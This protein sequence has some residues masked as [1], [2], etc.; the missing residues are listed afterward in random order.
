M[1]PS[2]RGSISGLKK[3]SDS[4][5]GLNNAK[6]SLPFVLETDASGFGLGAVLMQS[7]HPIAFFS[8]I[9]GPRARMKSVYKKEL[10]AIVLAVQKWRHY[11]PGHK[12]EIRTDQ[13]SIKYIMEQREVGADYQRWICKLMGYDFTIHYKPGPTNRVADALSR[14]VEDARTHNSMVTTGGVG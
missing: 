1:E 12:F 3:V 2:S 7:N 6:F 9:L 13:Q 14:K 11:L 8:K 5:S 4:G 10:M